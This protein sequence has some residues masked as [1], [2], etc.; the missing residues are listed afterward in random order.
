MIKFQSFQ[1]ETSYRSQ[2]RK[3][4]LYFYSHGC[5]PCMMPHDFSVVIFLKNCYFISQTFQKAS[6][7]HNAFKLS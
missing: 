2:D 7:M 5:D 6:F 4:F 3:F 1:F